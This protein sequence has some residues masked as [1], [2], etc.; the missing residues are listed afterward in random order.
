MDAEKMQRHIPLEGLSNFRDLGGYETRSGTAIKW[1]RIFRSDTLAGL[2]D[3]DIRTVERLGV[4]A[5]CD[6]RYG[7]ERRNEPSRLLDHPEIEVMEL[8]F[9]E[10]PGDLQ[11]VF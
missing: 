11:A 5:A 3:N 10:R 2:S 6:L 9:D 1:G 4:V 7:D 8:G